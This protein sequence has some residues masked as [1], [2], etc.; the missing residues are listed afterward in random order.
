MLHSLYEISKRV[1]NTELREQGL[2]VVVGLPESVH[3]LPVL[4][5]A[6]LHGAPHVEVES[7]L[8]HIA[9]GVRNFGE[10]T[11]RGSP[12]LVPQM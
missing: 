9:L 4:D 10:L 5:D 6:R 11:L 1:P 2:Q 8:G 3:G 7:A 12:S